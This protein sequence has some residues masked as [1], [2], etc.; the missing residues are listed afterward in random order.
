[1]LALVLLLMSCDLGTPSKPVRNNPIDQENPDT[2][3]DPYNLQAEL[4]NGGVRLIWRTVNLPNLLGYNIHRK[5][6][7]AESALFAAIGRDTVFTD[8]TIQNAR[9]YE[10]YVVAYS[11][12]READPSRI[13]HVTV[14]SEPV[15]VIE[16]E[17]AT[18]TPTR[19]VTLTMIAFGA[20][21]MLISNTADFAGAVWEDFA[22]TKAWRLATGAGTKTVH[23]R[24]AYTGGDTSLAVR[25]D[26]DPTPVS[27][28]V[29]INNEA[30]QTNTKRVTLT[31]QGVG[32]TEMQVS[33][34]PLQGNE[35]WQAFNADVN[36]DLALGAGTKT[37]F[38]NVRN[39]FLIEAPAQDAID[40]A[41]IGLSAS[42]NNGTAT[43]NRRH[44]SLKLP[45][46]GAIEMQVSNSPL[47]G[48]EPWI[49]Y[50]DSLGWDLTWGGET[51]TVFV[52]VHND[53]LIEAQAQAQIDPVAMTPSFDLVSDSVYINHP[54]VHLTMPRVGASQMLVINGSDSTG[55]VWLPYAENLAWNLTPGDG[56]KPV[57]IWF[58]SEFAI[59]GPHADSIGLDTQLNI[60]SFAWTHTG[61]DTMLIADRATFTLT[62]QD[63]AFGP[64]TMGHSAVN[65][66]GWAP[67]AAN[68]LGDGR[69]ELTFTIDVDTPQLRLAEVAV[70]IVDRA[71]NRAGPQAAADRLSYI[72]PA[73]Y[74]YNFPLANTGEI[75]TMCWT[76][77]GSFM[78]GR[79]PDEDIADVDEEPRHQVTIRQGFWLGKYEVT[80]RQWAAVMGNNPAAG[81]GCGEGDDYPVF[82]VNYT[83][84]QEFKNRIGNRFRL[85]SEAEWEYACR[86][87]QDGAQFPWGDD[88]RMIDDYCWFRDNAGNQSHPVGLKQANIW[89]L[90]DMLGNVWEWC[91]DHYHANYNGAPVDG[92]PWISPWL[93][94]RSIRGG[95]WGYRS[96]NCRSANRAL[97]PIEQRD[98]N[99][100]LR[101]ARSVNYPPLS[102]SGGFFGQ[103]E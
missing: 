75:I 23:M 88:Y 27:S 47:Q 2:Q 29:M 79:Q 25:D 58:R 84:T 33:N 4:A 12:E 56:W 15:V 74:E 82:R 51:K 28:T 101:L 94:N 83:E 91:E 87:R 65:V 92:S 11:Q 62:L 30:V 6:N 57:N 100:G 71:G 80:Q 18:D 99:L 61:A 89:N 86:A 20:A 49:A 77:P 66:A 10:Y 63:D 50:V 7:D 26:I 40:P 90:Y 16:S 60:I 103:G 64:E 69:Y 21:R 42:I 85:P 34:T 93:L 1:G 38:V 52:K 95:S 3:G 78:M 59:V 17:S 102:A 81:Q 96:E 35:P 31:I 37:V 68:D 41:P 45:A 54:D 53:F 55:G 76:P 32:A 5:D 19:D 98:N 97:W 48:N 39:D 72:L 36:W 70:N 22:P 13:A 8:R 67:L 24:I 46:V 44:V 73:G 9:R 43:T 14:N